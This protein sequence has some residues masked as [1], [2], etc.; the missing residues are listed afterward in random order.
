MNAPVPTPIYRLV[1]VDTLPT[2]LARDALHSPNHQPNDNLH[3][4]TI[5]NVNVQANR[6]VKL[7]K[8]GPQGS[9]HDYVPF[10]FGPLSVMLLNL[11]TGRVEGYDEGQEPIIY[12]TTTAQAIVADGCQFVFTDGHGLATFTEW[13]DDLSDLDQV[14]WGLVGERYWSDK[15]EDNDRQRRKQAEFLVWQ[16][17]HL[18][19]IS[20]IGVLNTNAQ[21]RVMETLDQFPRSHHPQVNV[22]RQWYYC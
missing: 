10:Y 16:F 17:C 9:V 12:L 19:L 20:E 22:R 14:D 13:Y 21:A 11:K 5:H 3:Y 7:V 6:R 1:H 15:P 18:S 8:C 4:R 2:L